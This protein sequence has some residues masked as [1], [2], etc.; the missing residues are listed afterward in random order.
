MLMQVLSGG[1]CIMSILSI[2]KSLRKVNYHIDFGLFWD[3]CYF[4]AMFGILDLLLY[5]YEV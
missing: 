3:M 1:I 2:H 4:R 5:L